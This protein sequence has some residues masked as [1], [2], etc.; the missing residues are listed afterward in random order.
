M[1]CIAK[2]TKAKKVHK[3]PAVPKVARE[4]QL[5]AEQMYQSLKAPDAPRTTPMGYIMGASMAMKLLFDQAVQ[6]G[7]DKEK[8]KLQAMTYVQAM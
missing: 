5:V 7:A 6:Q 3:K 2:P 1:A 8:L 4:A